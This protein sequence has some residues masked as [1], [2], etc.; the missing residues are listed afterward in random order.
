MAMTRKRA[1]GLALVILIVIVAL[2]AA[3]L[4]FGSS[5][6]RSKGTSAQAPATGPFSQE[7]NLREAV[8]PA[9]FD[10]RSFVPV[11][12]TGNSTGPVTY[13]KTRVMA[14]TTS[15]GATVLMGI[16]DGARATWETSLDGPLVAC[17]WITDGTTLPCLVKSSTGSLVATIDVTTGV[18]KWIWEDTENYA[19]ITLNGDKEI[20]LLG[21]DMSIT[22]ISQEG[23]LLAEPM[24]RQA[25]ADKT[26]TPDTSGC[27]LGAASLTTPEAFRQL[28]PTMYLVSHGGLNSFINITNNQVIG[29]VPGT[30]LFSPNDPS[31]RW[32]VAP[33]GGC[34][35]AAVI[36]PGRNRVQMLP[37]DVSVPVP[38]D[39]TI[40]K[41]VIRSGHLHTMNWDGPTI[42]RRAYSSLPVA[43]EGTPVI[44]DTDRFGVVA[45][46]NVV[47]AF[48]K[49]SGTELWSESIAAHDV[50]IAGDVII[51]VDKDGQVRGINLMS[52]SEQWTASQAALGSLT[53]SDDAFSVA[54]QQGL[55]QWRAGSSE[56]AV[57]SGA[58]A[59]VG[60]ISPGISY[61]PS[62]CVR[63]AKIEGQENHYTARTTPVDCHLEGAEPIVGVVTTDRVGRGKDPGDYLKACEDR[64]PTSVSMVTLTSPRVDASLSAICTGNPAL[65]GR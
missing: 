25:A 49:E 27:K 2:I 51:V 46:D 19:N 22:R 54:S 20:V 59:S 15:S 40:P 50:R 41:V 4:T 16:G 61:S 30:T 60:E 17:S 53:T 13:G 48:S 52:G 56:G 12:G 42:G 65:A 34:A 3:G 31:G 33:S 14:G 63:V 58:A 18:A 57:L 5:L 47:T 21:D 38:V 6:L 26:L 45:G 35:P 23:V 36:T 64:F 9:T 28:S 11:L 37:D 8:T 44:A 10:M 62:I 43:F 32:V 55:Y 24:L 39:H 1:L 29:A 7:P